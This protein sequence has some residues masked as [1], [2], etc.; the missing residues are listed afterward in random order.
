M[1]PPTFQ[2]NATSKSIHL[3]IAASDGSPAGLPKTGLAFNTAGLLIYYRRGATGAA[4]AITLATLANAQAAWSS[5]GFVQVDATNLPGVYRLDLP[6]AALATGVDTVLVGG[7]GTNI[8]IQPVTIDVPT[9]DVYAAGLTVSSIFD[10]AFSAAYNSLTFDEAIKVL[11]A[12]AAAKSSGMGVGT[13]TFR[14]LADTADVIVGTSDGAG[15]RTASTIT[16]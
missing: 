16:P 15:N 14:N 7:T 9:D 4:T 10:R 6:D 3:Y 11:L 2:K 5:G 1:L 8:V 12:A 13:P